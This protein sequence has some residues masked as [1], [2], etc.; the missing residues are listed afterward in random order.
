MLVPSWYRLQHSPHE[1]CSCGTMLGK[2]CSFFWFQGVFFFRRKILFLLLNSA[3]FLS[4][5]PRNLQSFPF[6]TNAALV[7]CW[8]VWDEVIRR[9][10][11][12]SCICFP[13]QP[14]R[15]INFTRLGMC[16]KSDDLYYIRKSSHSTDL[17][18][19]VCW[20]TGT[21]LFCC[22]VL[23][24]GNRLTFVHGSHVLWETGQL[25]PLPVRRVKWTTT[26]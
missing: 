25:G 1:W 14:R 20:L 18:K 8:P 16:F 19:H 2:R 5:S 6:P 3:S 17:S 7:G 26:K 10:F 13:T 24:F 12:F 21:R 15:F 22:S 11:L 9:K 23:V 4:S